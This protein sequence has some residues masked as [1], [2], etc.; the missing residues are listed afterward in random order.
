M[1]GISKPKPN[2]QREMDKDGAATPEHEMRWTVSLFRADRDLGDAPCCR[3]MC[4][5]TEINV[6][7]QRHRSHHVGARPLPTGQVRSQQQQAGPSLR[8]LTTTQR[9]DEAA[10]E[11]LKLF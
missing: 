10:A 11:S 4:V 3:P 6:A 8:Q 5:E 2:G 7:E 1:A 9:P